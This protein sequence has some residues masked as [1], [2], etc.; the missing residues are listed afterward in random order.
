MFGFI[1][2]HCVYAQNDDAD[3]LIHLDEVVITQTRLQN[4]AIGHY[5]QHVDS[6][7]SKF[8]VVS[9]AA[10]LLRKFGYGHIRSY[11]VGG[12]TTPSFRGTGGSHTAVL[13]NG[14]NIASPLNGTADLTLLPVTFIDDVQLQSGGSASLYGSGAIGGTIQFNSKAVFKQGLSVSLTENA[15]SFKTLFHGLS[16][17]WSDKKWI[18][19]TKIFQTSSENNFP[20]INGNYTPPRNETRQHNALAQHGVLQQNYFQVNEKQLLSFRFWYQDNHYEIPEPTTVASPGESTQRDK[21]FRSM[22]G[23]TY[24][25]RNGHLFVQSANVHHTLDYQDPITE[26]FSSNTFN[27][28]INTFENTVDVRPHLEWTSGV[29]YTFEQADGRELGGDPH[30]NRIALYTAFKHNPGKWSNVLSARQESANGSLTPFAPSL[31]AEYRFNS[32]VSLFGNGSRNYRIPTFNDLYWSDALAKGNPDLAMEKSWSEEIGVKLKTPTK[33]QLT[34]QAALFSNQ[35]DNLILWTQTAGIWSPQNIREAWTRG[36]ETMGTLRRTLGKVAG[37]VTVRY[38][39]TLA[40]TRAVYDPN[41]ADEIGNQLV[42]TPKH[43]S[44]TTLRLTWHSYNLSLINNYTGRQYTDDSNNEYYAL[45][46]YNIANV[47]LSKDLPLKRLTILVM[48]EMNNLFDSQ[49]SARPGYPLPGRN[50][51]AGFTIR[52]NKPISI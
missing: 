47:W 15:G 7:T 22:I 50:F 30:R 10:E 26:L 17:S 49:V 13:W 37:E 42:F 46:A 24:D 6:T 29:N 3:S 4:Y 39:Y 41:K 45:K 11:G 5:M 44:G 18:S 12:V 9:N 14:I 48:F 35:V 23:W 31:G 38:S 36:L 28:F 2:S 8:A 19:S 1:S 16:V 33:N 52:F 40:T 20:F 25:Y 21:F 51:K 43:E 32:I 27:S 34:A